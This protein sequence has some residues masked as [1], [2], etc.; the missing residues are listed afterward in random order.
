MDKFKT[1]KKFAWTHKTLTNGQKILWRFYFED[2][3]YDTYIN[4][5]KYHRYKTGHISYEFPNNIFTGGFL[6]EKYETLKRYV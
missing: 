2:I 1:V 3:K 6:Y 4:L 5:E